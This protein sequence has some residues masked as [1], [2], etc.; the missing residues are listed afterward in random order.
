MDFFAK[1]ALIDT[2]FVFFFY[3]TF[4]V[5]VFY[6][7]NTANCPVAEHTLYRLALWNGDGEC[8]G[9]AIGPRHEIKINRLSG[10]TRTPT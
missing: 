8:M 7:Q 9:F 5:S 6:L 1:L 10:G 2:I 3:W 4:I